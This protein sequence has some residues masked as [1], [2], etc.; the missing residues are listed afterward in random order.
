MLLVTACTAN[1]FITIVQI[2][3]V[4]ITGGSPTDK[5]APGPTPTATT[6]GLDSASPNGSQNGDMDSIVSSGSPSTPDSPGT[7][8]GSM[9][10]AS[11]IAS[12]SA[13]ASASNTL[14]QPAVHWDTDISDISQL[15]PSNHSNLYYSSSG[16]AGMSKLIAVLFCFT[17]ISFID[18]SE[19]HLF[20]QLST[21]F[22]YPS[23]VLEHSVYVQLTTLDGAGLLITFSSADAY[24]YAKESWSAIPTFVLVTYTE[25]IGNS[26]DQRAFWLIQKIIAGAY[27]N[28]ILAEAK[29]LAIENAISGI[30]MAWGTHTPTNS[31][32]MNSSMSNSGSGTT[33]G[34]QGSGNG[35]KSGATNFLTGSGSSSASS[36]TNATCG[37]PPASTIE[38]FPAAKCGASDF[39]EILDDAIGYL[40]FNDTRDFDSSIEDFAPGLT[41]DNASDY[42]DEL[43]SKLRRRVKLHR[44]GW[45]SSIVRKVAGVSD[46][47]SFANNVEILI[48]L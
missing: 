43:S 48:N 19:Q 39:D 27:Q 16:T 13:Q 42:E 12:P 45:F 14:L 6:L 36:S 9:L 23:V 8:M 22:S 38:E 41:D 24:V 15:A 20:G 17:D 35:T 3:T 1:S 4:Y 11:S 7:A 18:P 46:D 21:N 40:D 37:Q 26:S 34:S 33:T 28:A 44:R 31:T 47:S 5:G 2:S 25:G 32:G 10:I 30:D 29:E